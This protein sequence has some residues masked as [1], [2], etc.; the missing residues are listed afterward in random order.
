[1]VHFAVAVALAIGGDPERS[2]EIVTML[3]G[4]MPDVDRYQAYRETDAE[5]L[6]QVEQAIAASVASADGEEDRDPSW[7]AVSRAGGP[8]RQGELASRERTTPPSLHPQA[9]GIP[10]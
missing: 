3:S 4:N 7:H 6:A 1:M 10:T 5:F 8:K 9:S 2:R